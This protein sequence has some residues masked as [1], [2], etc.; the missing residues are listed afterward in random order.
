L[1]IIVQVTLSA[2]VR[3]HRPGGLLG[4]CFTSASGNVRWKGLVKIEGDCSIRAFH[5]LERG[6][7][8]SKS[9]IESLDMNE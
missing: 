7:V 4:S 8:L 9:S 6:E 3:S 1:S 2:S 5:Q